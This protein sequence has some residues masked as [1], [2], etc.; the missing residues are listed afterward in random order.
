MWRFLCTYGFS[1]ETTHDVPKL[2]QENDKS[3][4]TVILS[5]TSYNPNKLLQINNCQLNLQ[6]YTL[7]DITEGNRTQITTHALEGTRDLSQVSER[8]WS[9]LPYPPASSRAK[10]CSAIETSF[11]L[12]DF[13]FLRRPLRKWI[14]TPHQNWIWFLD[15]YHEILYGKK[16]LISLYTSS[17]VADFGTQHATS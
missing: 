4:M 6:I 2:L 1:L 13:R 11:L 8:K 16:E 14:S 5:R 3:I 12:R 17:L 10:W 7:V 9:N 15:Q